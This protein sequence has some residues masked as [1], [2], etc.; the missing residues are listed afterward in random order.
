M[1]P[2]RSAQREAYRQTQWWWWWWWW[3]FLI[4]QRQ[5]GI[6]PTGHAGVPM[7]AQCRAEKAVLDRN[8]TAQAKHALERGVTH[9]TSPWQEHVVLYLCEVPRADVTA[10]FFQI[11]LHDRHCNELVNGNSF[12]SI[13]SCLTLKK[14][15]KSREMIEIPSTG[16]VAGRL[17]LASKLANFRWPL[18]HRVY[19]LVKM[20]SLIQNC[21]N[22]DF[23]L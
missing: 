3:W 9:T 15:W 23:T 5:V 14:Q 8:G 21:L 4:R 17:D 12:R 1:K 20:L 10:Q 18:N 16:L 13:F 19:N 22:S 11:L 2:K 7:Q 6:G